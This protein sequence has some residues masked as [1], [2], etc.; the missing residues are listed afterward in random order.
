M[1]IPT[2]PHHPITSHPSSC[3]I[4]GS[5][6]SDPH[7]PASQWPKT[8]S[9]S[10]PTSTHHVSTVDCQSPPRLARVRSR[11]FHRIHRA[12]PKA[13]S[14]SSNTCQY[15]VRLQLLTT[16]SYPITLTT[17][18]CNL[19]WSSNSS[20]THTLKTCRCVPLVPPLA[21]KASLASC[22]TYRRGWPNSPTNQTSPGACFFSTMHDACQPRSLQVAPS[23][24]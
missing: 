23:A 19:P 16:T 3:Y 13:E 17:L 22:T 11:P 1:V 14:P 20:H 15:T 5:P 10:H 4:L 24:N 6:F 12:L 8:H 18:L 21:F 9:L 2:F 7:I